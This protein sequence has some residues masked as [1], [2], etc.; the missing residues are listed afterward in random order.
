MVFLYSV[1]SSL[2]RCSTKLQLSVSVSVSLSREPTTSP[3]TTPP[4]SPR[5]VHKTR[6]T[7]FFLFFS[8]T[9]S[10]DEFSSS[11]TVVTESES[12]A[13]DV[14]SNRHLLSERNEN[15]F[16][17]DLNPV[18]FTTTPKLYE[19]FVCTSPLLN[20]L[21]KIYTHTRFRLW[22]TL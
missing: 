12:I 7:Q 13:D 3:V 5:H 17:T 10:G 8:Y 19:T 2:Y 14:P 11:T 22:K 6:T 9:L 15:V 18:L 1:G 21:K 4:P 20:D 16:W